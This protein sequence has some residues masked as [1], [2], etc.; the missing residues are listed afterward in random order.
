[1]KIS[2]RYK[3]V[4]LL[5]LFLISTSLVFLK[6]SYDYFLQDKITSVREIQTLQSLQAA[7]DFSTRLDD[8]RSQL[9]EI[10]VRMI[11]P[12][13]GS[14]NPA[15]FGFDA[16]RA[17]DKLW[18]KDAASAAKLAS[19]P[20]P[21]Y[22]GKWSL[23]PLKAGKAESVVLSEKIT[24]QEKLSTREIVIVALMAKDRVLTVRK[25]DR[26]PIKTLVLMDS[27][28][29]SPEKAI[30]AATSEALGLFK[31][32]SALFD[33]KD[34]KK[35]FFE[36][37]Q[38]QS[39]SVEDEMGATRF[40]FA[41]SPLQLAGLEQRWV[42][43]SV[44]SFES[45][46]A[47]LQ[48]F[49]YQLIFGAVII[50][51]LSFLAALGLA[52]H[53]AN[54]L[55][56]IVSATRLLETGKFETRV[57]VQQKDEIGDLARAFNH[58]GQS[59]AD[60]EKA[61]IEA[62]ASLVQ[63]EK[64]ATL[65]TLSAGI[66]HEVKNPLAGIMGNA[67]LALMAT[68]GI[69][70]DKKSKLDNYLEIIKKEA[71]RTRGI[72]DGLMR[73]SRKESAAL[74]P[75]DLELVIWDTIQLMEHSLNMSGV[76]VKKKFDPRIK[77]V[78]G[79]GNQI[80]QVLLN[81]MQNAGHAMPK[82]GILEVGTVYFDDK[83]Q[84]SAPVGQLTAYRHPD[85]KGAFGRIFIKDNG[86]GMSKEVMR[87]IFEP[88]FTTKEAG[89]GT[90]LGLAVT[91]N[92]LTEHKSR[93]SITSEVGKGT[94]FLIDFM[95]SSERTAEVLEKLKV[96]HDRYG[97]DAEPLAPAEPL[98]AAPAAPVLGAN[99]SSA[100]KVLPPKPPLPMAAPAPSAPP[101]TAAPASP[102]TGRPPVLS[103]IPRRSGEAA[104]ELFADSKSEVS[105]SKFSIRKPSGSK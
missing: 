34:W 65:G 24:L 94:E 12:T 47:S 83:A 63:S 50:L 13:R 8:I 54:P 81:M 100:P 79:N 2:I 1:M 82:G 95:T 14:V 46:L 26:G 29:K 71:K 68:Q 37:K 104:K 11:D 45:I 96:Y 48:I 72:I 15:D 52:R 60:R 36:V 31:E 67:D 17:G 88:F 56:K 92:I 51:G 59:L 30:F 84:A 75:T 21:S 55:E 58:M 9:R 87:K 35:S 49:F 18:Q 20:T 86:A 16:I 42:V 38:T 40:L 93:I 76:Q 91:M 78:T 27:A 89:K 98:P 99:E 101:A 25:L 62:Q 70:G 22:Q 41:V 77:M 85:F 6:L 32:F 73:F 7:R 57:D 80:E 10:A 3:L 28:E 103:G 69:D 102:P 66:A 90:G 23:A 39:Q 74:Q 97:G 44:V 33:R 5:G 61:L 4:L 19:L 43:T 105:M 53:F 64:L